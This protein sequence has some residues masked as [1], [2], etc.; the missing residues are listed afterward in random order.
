MVDSLKE[1][2]YF[3][4]PFF[5]TPDWANSTR[6][7]TVSLS[8]KGQVPARDL[9]NADGDCAPKPV[10]S[11]PA[12]PQPAVAESQKTPSPTPAAA[13]PQA[14]VGS[15]AGD[16]AGPPMP[17]G[18]VS[19]PPKRKPTQLADAGAGVDIGPLRPAGPAGAG[20]Q[21]VLGGVALGMTE[22]Q[23]VRRAGHPSHVT[24]TAGKKGRRKVVLT[25]LTGPWPGVYTFESGRLKEVNAAPGELKPAT[26]RK[27]QYRRARAAS[28][29]D[30]Y[31]Q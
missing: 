31:V 8:P 1:G 14:N 6:Y 19:P 11:Q 7:K 4:Q 16:L 27:R 29:T 18:P 28:K 13:R 15:I 17:Q 24:I 25:Y 23:A 3:S 12:K 21:P 26:P 20:G 10:Q 5:T 30:V 22:C 9:V 2:D